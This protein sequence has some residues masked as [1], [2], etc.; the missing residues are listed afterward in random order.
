MKKGLSGEWLAYLA[1][2][3][4]AV[5]LLLFIAYPIGKTLFLAFVEPGKAVSIGA[6]GLANFHAFFTSPLY[7]EALGHT[8]PSQHADRPVRVLRKACP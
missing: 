2:A 3:L 1:A 6:L 5:V 7:Q 8:K 4:S